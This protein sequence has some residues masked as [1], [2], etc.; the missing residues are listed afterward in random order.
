MDEIYWQAQYVI[1]VLEENRKRC[2]DCGRQA[3]EA[4]DVLLQV[5]RSD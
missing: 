2:D 4:L 5:E 1:S 3:N